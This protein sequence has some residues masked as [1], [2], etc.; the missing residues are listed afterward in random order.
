MSPK[1]KNSKPGKEENDPADTQQGTSV[2]EAME[3]S[4]SL[5]V[6]KRTRALKFV[7]VSRQY[8][9]GF[10]DADEQK[11][12]RAHVMQ[13]FVRHKSGHE[14]LSIPAAMKDTVQEHVIRFRYAKRNTLRQNAAPS[15][16]YYRKIAMNR[17]GGHKTS[18][19]PPFRIE[20]IQ[21]SAEAIATWI[22]PPSDEYLAD[23]TDVA[24]PP[25]TLIRSSLLGDRDHFA[26]LPIDASRAT[27]RMLHYCE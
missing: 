18:A 26:R 21:P 8:S 15:T 7:D 2:S 3:P 9:D 22:T 1:V 23:S 19:T 11:A 4:S 17:E 24:V 12:I 13:D 6:D 25:S 20:S 5:H 27:H 16:S 10:Y 14:E